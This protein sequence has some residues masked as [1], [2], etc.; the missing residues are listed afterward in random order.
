MCEDVGNPAG[1]FSH[2]D[3][4]WGAMTSLSHCIAPDSYYDI[5]LR[6]I[7]SEPYIAAGTVAFFIFIN[8]VDTFLLLSL[9]VALV[10]G[11]FKRVREKY[12][13]SGMLTLEQL[14]ELS[15]AH[16]K[17]EPRLMRPNDQPAEVSIH[18]TLSSGVTNIEL[19]KLMWQGAVSLSE[20]TIY[21]A[22]ITL[23]IILQICSMVLN[24]EVESP[25]ANDFV[26]LSNI[27]CTSIFVFDVILNCVAAGS[28]TKYWDSL[29]NKCESILVISGIIGLATGYKLLI[30]IP[31]LRGYRLIAY[32]PTLRHM[33]DSAGASAQVLFNVVVFFI[34][35]MIVFTVA[36]RYM[37]DARIGKIS[38]TNF[39]NLAQSSFTMLQLLTGDSWSGVL[40]SAMQ[41]FPQDYVAQF[42][43]T[44]LVIIWFVFSNLIAK[45]VFI[46][47]IL[48]NFSINDTL[49]AMRAPGMVSMIRQSIRGT[50]K[51]ALSR[52]NAI[53]QGRLNLDTNTGLVHPRQAARQH[54]LKMRASLNKTDKVQSPPGTGV[55]RLNVYQSSIMQ[56]SSTFLAQ[57]PIA[58]QEPEERV[59]F[60][61]EL[62]NPIRQA[63]LWIAKHSAFD[64][65]VFLAILTTC[66]FL[67]IERP[68]KDMVLY[69]GTPDGVY[70]GALVPVNHDTIAF[71]ERISTYVFTVEFICRVMAH[72]LILTKNAYLKSGWN[73]MD[74]VV[75][76]V[77]WLQ[78]ITG[79]SNNVKVLRVAQALKP[80][81]LI[82]RNPSMR[83]IVSVFLQNLA[84]LHEAI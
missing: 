81:R 7:Q 13:I 83:A 3:N 61:L 52:R 8:A 50:I 16:T 42:F 57:K 64:S 77:A 53:I 30:V 6:A 72:G 40:Y 5:L 4:V 27:I 26:Y 43:G 76:V 32:T 67:I 19:E 34:S 47:A 49:Q 54:L 44:A 21:Q 38:R 45:N 35:M 22:M 80:L 60:F 82:K 18:R 9:F 1:G 11:T 51:T 48:E 79:E 39:D 74:T 69:P 59:L 17:C 66:F 70:Q 78:E 2:F 65:L 29:L 73:I 14:K 46:A 71:V 37:F 58:L 24:V 62:S 36:A 33:L 55:R 75:L 84:C 28:L 68:Y 25:V 63:F 56:V 20:S 31:A 23:T 10:T 15:V 12:S 41:A